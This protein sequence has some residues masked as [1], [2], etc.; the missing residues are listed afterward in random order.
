MIINFSELNKSNLIQYAVYKGGTNNNAG[1]EPLTKLFK[2]GGF[3]A[4]IGVS[5]GF[6]RTSKEKNGKKIKGSNAFI[7]LV[8]TGKQK[9][10]PNTYDEDTGVFTY[11]GD[12]RI[13]GNDVLNTKKSGNEILQDIFNKSYSGPEER[14]NIPPIFIFKST[15]NRRDTRFIGLAVPGVKGMS[16]S[17]A[18]ELRDF[19][20]YKNYVAHFMVL[21]ISGGVIKREWLKDLKD[22]SFDFSENAPAEWNNYILNG[23][24]QINIENTYETSNSYEVIEIKEDDY[25]NYNNEVDRKIKVRV[26]QGKF[27]D[28]LIKRDKWCILCGLDIETLLIASHIK[29]W[30]KSDN[31]EKQ[32]SDNGIL[33]CANHDALFDKGYISFDKDNNLC[34]SH[35]IKELDYD[36]LYINKDMKIVIND[37][38]KRYMEYHR[39]NIFKIHKQKAG[40]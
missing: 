18:L 6:R 15:G 17:E 9:E 23:L 36:K 20:T 34:I 14:S 21:K 19:G 37:K 25:L 5:G 40:L 28:E 3:K 30:S 16:K 26:T 12:N 8:D 38:Q 31:Y 4:G 29:P 39:V 1:D 13:E 33:L 24:N 11:Y 22:A 32:D 10:W 27:R 2:I 7:A 35:L